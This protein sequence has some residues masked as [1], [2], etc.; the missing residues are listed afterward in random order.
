MV[1]IVRLQVAI[2]D[3]HACSNEHNMT[4]DQNY[5]KTKP[6]AVA[7]APKGK[8]AA[9]KCAAK[10]KEKGQAKKQAEPKRKRETSPAHRKKDKLDASMVAK[11]F[12]FIGESPRN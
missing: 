4:M 8:T 11:P 3:C 6:L 1:L 7:M 2:A 12:D 9:K 10:A 5:N